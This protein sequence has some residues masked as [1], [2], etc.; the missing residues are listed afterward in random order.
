MCRSFGT[1]RSHHTGGK[2]VMKLT[3]VGACQCGVTVLISLLSVFLKE[4]IHVHPVACY[5]W[6]LL[7]LPGLA[8]SSEGKLGRAARVWLLGGAAD[9][10]CLLVQPPL[11]SCP[12]CGVILLSMS[13]M[14]ACH[15]DILPWACSVCCLPSFAPS[16]PLTLP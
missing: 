5:R 11:P 10:T 7:L 2:N 4:Q 13:S 15:M 1:G 8:C 6:L 14:K 9:F 16:P 3:L 12:F